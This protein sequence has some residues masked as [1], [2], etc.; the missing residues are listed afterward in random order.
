VVITR[1]VIIIRVV[2]CRCNDKIACETSEK[3]VIESDLRVR[4]SAVLQCA[5]G[6]R[7][8]TKARSFDI[9]SNLFHESLPCG[10]LLS[11][12]ASEEI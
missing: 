9:V 1:R 6:L 2:A 11:A 3:S 10:K 7:T 5:G 8:E 4:T 12:A